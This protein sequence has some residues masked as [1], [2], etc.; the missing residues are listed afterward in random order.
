MGKL[1]KKYTRT[2]K[3]QNKK[4]RKTTRRVR[5][6]GG[7]LHQRE[8]VPHYHLRVQPP[9]GCCYELGVLHAKSA[10]KELNNTDKNNTDV[11]SATI[12]DL[13]TAII[14]RESASSW[15]VTLN[16]PK[17]SWIMNPN[18][19]GETKEIILFWKGKALLNDNTKL[20]DIIVDGE[21]LPLYTHSKEIE[22]ITFKLYDNLE[23][24][25]VEVIK[26]PDPIFEDTPPDE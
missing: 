18:N 7:G 16:K 23:Y 6:K 11:K 13:K 26:H 25:S 14:N 21:R 3:K 19:P 2:N 24:P 8:D 4:R 15:D 5:V 1:S 10:K 12:G 20:R 17:P 9:I 22:P